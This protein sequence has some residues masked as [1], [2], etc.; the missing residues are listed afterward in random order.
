MVKERMGWMNILRPLSGIAAT[1]LVR[2]EGA[3]LDGIGI[4]EILHEKQSGHGQ[5]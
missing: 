3:R 2:R 1:R 4:A 5:C